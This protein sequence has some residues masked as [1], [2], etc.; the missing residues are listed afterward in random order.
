MKIAVSIAVTGG[1]GGVA[2]NLYTL[3]TVMASHTV[4]IYTMRFIPRGLV[5]QGKNVSIR[6]FEQGPQG[7]C[8]TLYNRLYDLYIYYASRQPIYLGSHLNARKKAVLPNGNDV[9]AIET[10]FDYVLCQADDG[11]RYFEDLTKKAI[12]EPCVTLPVDHFE[13]IEGLPDKYFLTVFNP[14]DLDREYSDGFKPYKGQDLLY[15]TADHFALPLI[16]CHGDEAVHTEHNLEDHPNIIH[17]HNLAQEKMY[18]LYQQAAAYVSFSR[19]EGY[20]WAIA[21]A[22]LFDKPVISRRVGVLSSFDPDQ[23]GLHLYHSKEELIKLI[24]RDAFGAGAYDKS[25]F[26]P[27]RFENKLMNLI[28]PD[29]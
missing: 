20:G 4:D 22:M 9:R 13:S 2:R 12:I 18:Y 11:I 24:S 23:H 6:W 25:I 21:D 10:H 15:E 16:W 7:P 5:P 17:F 14:Y 28:E 29:I 19:E 27:K 8:I 3:S 26:S 1:T